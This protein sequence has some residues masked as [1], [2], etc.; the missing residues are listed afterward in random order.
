VGNGRIVNNYP[1]TDTVS[2]ERTLKGSVGSNPQASI[3]AAVGN[4]DIK[5]Q[6]SK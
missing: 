6:R 4:G 1:I 5:V 3:T 2:D